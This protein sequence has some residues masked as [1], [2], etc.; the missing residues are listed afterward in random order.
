MK[1]GTIPGLPDS[2]AGPPAWIGPV[3]DAESNSRFDAWELAAVAIGAAASKGTPLN[4]DTVEYYNRISGL[5]ASTVALGRRV[6]LVQSA[7]SLADSEKFVDYSGF[8]LQPL[9]R[10][11]RAASPGSTCRP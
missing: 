6:H 11:T 8:T 3:G 9:A 5:T 10:P 2:M 4:V 7:D 1:T